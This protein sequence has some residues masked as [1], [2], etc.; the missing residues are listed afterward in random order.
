MSTAVTVKEL[1]E[2]NKELAKTHT[3][4][5]NYGDFPKLGL[6]LPKVL[7]ITCVD[8]RCTPEHFLGLQA[9]D[10]A[11]IRNVC[12]HVAP[13]IDNIL[14]LDALMT[15][16]ELMIIH[17]SGKNPVPSHLR[18][19]TDA[20][21]L[22]CGALLFTDDGLRSSLKKQHPEHASKI[23]SVESYGAITE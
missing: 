10:A 12:G 21:R 19:G 22:D 23:D 20:N 15:F 4:K 3:P 9:A 2:R 8:P 14:A 6:S 18:H 16:N 1:I 17:H 7:I 5:P 11:V 13:A